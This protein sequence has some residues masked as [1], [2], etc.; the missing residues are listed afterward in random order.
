MWAE[1]FIS[2]SPSEALFSVL[3]YEDR[4]PYVSRLYQIINQILEIQGAQATCNDVR[5]TGLKLVF[6]KIGISVPGVQPSMRHTRL[7]QHLTVS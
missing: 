2:E 1:S 4:R 5:L 6:Y 7:L 3:I